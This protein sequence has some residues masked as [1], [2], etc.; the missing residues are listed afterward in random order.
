MAGYLGST[1][2]PQA[3]QHRESFTATEGQTSFATAGYTP[4]FLDVFLNGSHL[5]PAD[6]V[7]TNGS[8]VVLVVAA[9]ADDVCDIVSYT[10]FEVAG[11]TFTGTTT[12]TDV[13]AASLDISGNVDID[14]V[15]NLD[16]VDID[17]AVDMASTLKVA[18]NVAFGGQAPS[19]AG[20]TVK[21]NGSG[22]TNGALELLAADGNSLSYITNVANLL[23][24]SDGDGNADAIIINAAGEVTKPNQPAF[25]VK[26][27][28]VQT[29][30]AINSAVTVVFGTE[31]MDI[32]GN[33]AGNVFTVPVTGVYQFNISITVDNLD[34]SA[35]YYEARLQTSNEL[36]DF[37][38]DPDFGQDA[39]F[40]T[41]A[42][43][44]TVKL[45]AGD[46]AHVTFVQGGG[47]AQTDIR[48]QSR[49][50]GFL[51]C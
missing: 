23:A 2:V 47:S 14:G 1:P 36:I 33:F 28:S 17:G 4:Q 46:T 6:F 40:F 19:S 37:T 18:A 29:N 34:S 42:G 12:M 48:V 51:A 10:P 32:G 16:V 3:T 9:S 45:D 26:P 30:I 38:F 25:E 35:T 15:T 44:V 24:L 11:A 8:D 50:S 7:A 49:F 22:Y 43:S 39:A 21:A 20:L 13:V 27:A 41:F 5:S 31:L